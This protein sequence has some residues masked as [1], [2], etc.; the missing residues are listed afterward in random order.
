MNSVVVIVTLALLV[1][2][3]FNIMH[4]GST[5]A[6]GAE[7]PDGETR[8]EIAR[9]PHQVLLHWVLAEKPLKLVRVTIADAVEPCAIRRE[10]G[11]VVT[12]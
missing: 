8:V 4:D 3:G 10:P 6:E 5:L 9:C 11:L 12:L 1:A 7:E 2:L